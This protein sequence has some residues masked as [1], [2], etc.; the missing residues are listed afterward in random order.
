MTENEPLKSLY[1]D[2]K[3]FKETGIRLLPGEILCVRNR[4]IKNNGKNP[5][6]IDDENW[7]ELA[8]DCYGSDLDRP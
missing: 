5:I 4:Y 7:R 2:S 1:E 8:E 6:Y 3:R